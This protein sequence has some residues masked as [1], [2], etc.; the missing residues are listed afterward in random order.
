MLRKYSSGC[1]LDAV[2]ASS[3]E[4][5]SVSQNCQNAL[6]SVLP[7]QRV[8]GSNPVPRSIIH[9]PL[10]T[11]GIPTIARSP[12]MVDPCDRKRPGG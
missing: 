12:G 1:G 10:K 11:L 7:K 6:T 3:A 4:G 8:A 2:S 5:R 9:V